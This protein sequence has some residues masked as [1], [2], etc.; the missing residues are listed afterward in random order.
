MAKTFAKICSYAEEEGEEETQIHNKRLVKLALKKYLK[1][2]YNIRLANKVCC[3]IDW[4]VTPMDYNAFYRQL[5]QT[6]FGSGNLASTELDFLPHILTLKQTAFALFDMNCDG[7]VC[8]Y[9]LYSIINNTDNKLFI[10]S[11]NRDFKDIKAKM[12]QK[13]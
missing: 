9:D 6:I 2:R 13:H 8:E 7:F 12:N 11:I 10:N 4:S 1:E 5:D 3:L